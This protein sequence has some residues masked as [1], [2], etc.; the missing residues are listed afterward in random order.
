MSIRSAA[1][2]A[3]PVTVPVVIVGAGAGGLTAALAARE[4]GAE[5]LVVERDLV[6]SGSTA[7]SSGLIPAAGTRWQAAKG[8]AD[9]PSR[10]AADIMAKNKHRADPA[11]VAVVAAT[12][13]PTLEWLASGMACR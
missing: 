12:A 10:F 4:T 3:F 13:G 2:V 1:G 8:V 11:I 6:P 7:L 9:D 5:V